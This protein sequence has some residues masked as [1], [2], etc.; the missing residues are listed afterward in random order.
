MIMHI[1]GT[2]F[3]GSASQIASRV[4]DI[5][6]NKAVIIDCSDIKTID[7]SG[8]FALEDLILTLKDRGVHVVI[9][10][11]SRSIAALALKLGLRRIISPNSL[12]FSKEEA[13]KN[14]E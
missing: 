5:W 3:F 9:I 2:L 7:I 10:F 12:A 6:N 13:L 1:D 11:S 14:L 4:E 8:V